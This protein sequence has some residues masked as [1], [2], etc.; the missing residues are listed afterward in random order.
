M[1][2]EEER[3]IE[4]AATF[5]ALEPDSPLLARPLYLYRI[6]NGLTVAQM[7]H[8]LGLPEPDDF[9]RL[10]VCLAPQTAIASMGWRD[11]AAVLS[12]CFPTLKLNRLH[13]AV[14]A[15]DQQDFMS[16]AAS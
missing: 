9:Y 12:R 14:Q 3:P 7:A 13:M 1:K 6:R 5:A 11:Y 4:L 15:L 16:T 2:T 8:W 10:A